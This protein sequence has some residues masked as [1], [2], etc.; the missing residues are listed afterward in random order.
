M[1]CLWQRDCIAASLLVM[2]QSPGATRTLAA[3]CFALGTAVI[4]LGNLWGGFLCYV[5]WTGRTDPGFVT[6][7]RDAAN[8]NAP[9]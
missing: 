5:E 2:T 7:R 3:L 1:P 6:P 8:R 9:P 4:L